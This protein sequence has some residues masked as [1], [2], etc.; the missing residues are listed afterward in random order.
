[1]KVS[2]KKKTIAYAAISDPIME[3]RIAVAKNKR[4]VDPLELDGHLFTLETEI[5]KRLKVALNIEGL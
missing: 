1:M 2:E 3:F 5:W 4:K